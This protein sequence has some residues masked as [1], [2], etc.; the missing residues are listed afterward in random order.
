MSRTWTTVFRTAFVLAVATCAAARG[1]SQATYTATQQLPQFTIFAGGSI[2]QP[3]PDYYKNNQKAYLF[4]ADYNFSFH[5]FYVD[6]SLEARALISPVEEEVGEK[7]F[8]GGLKLS[9]S[10]HGRYRPYGDFLVGTGTITYLP[11]L[12]GPNAF[13]DN[14]IVYTYGGGVDIDIWRHV[15]LK[16]DYQGSRWHTGV[17]TT[18]HPRSL[19]LGVVYSF[20][21][22]RNR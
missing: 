8:S 20:G 9:H 7:T 19:N 6:P 10:Y 5:H 16:V 2:I 11:A 17:N 4:G 21:F 13:S 12:Y 1:F 14:S 22:S 15:G 18:F 3:Q